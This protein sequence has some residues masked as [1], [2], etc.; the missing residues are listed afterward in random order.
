LGTIRPPTIVRATDKLER[1][2]YTGRLGGYAWAW[3][4]SSADK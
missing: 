2:L 1:A 3:G 4:D